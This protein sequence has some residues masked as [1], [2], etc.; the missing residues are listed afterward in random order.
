MEVSQICDYYN[1]DGGSD[2]DFCTLEEI[3]LGKWI[4]KHKNTKFFKYNDI[5]IILEERGL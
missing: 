2:D 3:L 5:D 1:M 4:D